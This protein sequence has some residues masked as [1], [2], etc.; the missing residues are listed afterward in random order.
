MFN[1]LPS[2]IWMNSYSSSYS[3]SADTY[4]ALACGYAE[5]GEVGELQS[6]FREAEENNISLSVPNYLSIISSLPAEHT[7]FVD[8]VIIKVIIMNCERCVSVY[9]IILFVKTFD[10]FTFVNKGDNCF[11]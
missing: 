11:F 4:T 7:D 2:F 8:M 10:S 6:V 1:C 9:F 5:Q 3:P